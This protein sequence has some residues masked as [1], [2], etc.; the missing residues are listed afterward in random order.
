[1]Y[2]FIHTFP[3]I[4]VLIGK[5]QSLMMHKLLKIKNISMDVFQK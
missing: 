3:V 4:S 2:Y 1:M 5:F